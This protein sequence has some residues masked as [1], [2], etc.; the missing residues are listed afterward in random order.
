MAEYRLTRG[1]EVERAD[2][3]IIP[4]DDMN[5]DWQRY[6]IWLAAGGKPDDA[7]IPAAPSFAANADFKRALAAA[8]YLE[9]TK[10]AVEQVGGLAV[11]LWYSAQTFNR[12]DPLVSAVGEV[13]AAS[14]GKTPEEAAA[15][16]EEIFKAA[17]E[18]AHG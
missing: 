4:A 15:I 6:S 14:L 7:R 10:A 18:L 13:L 12:N 1:A 16:V 5:P 11:E 8:G 17:S 9:Q 3:A 2:G